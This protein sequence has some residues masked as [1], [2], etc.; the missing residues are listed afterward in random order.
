M[1]V[2]VGVFERDREGG[3]E[4]QRKEKTK[5]GRKKERYREEL[6]DKTDFIV[7]ESMRVMNVLLPHIEGFAHQT[8]A[9]SLNV[10]TKEKVKRT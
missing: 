3:S 8:P 1:C 5:K 10:Y 9:V 7:R 4:R 2:W 6:T